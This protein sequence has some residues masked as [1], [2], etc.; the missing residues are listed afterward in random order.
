MQNRRKVEDRLTHGKKGV[1]K[2]DNYRLTQ[3][4]NSAGGTICSRWLSFV[5]IED[6]GLVLRQDVFILNSSRGDATQQRVKERKHLKAFTNSQD[7][8]VRAFE[9]YVLTNMMDS[10]I[11]SKYVYKNTY[12]IHLRN[13]N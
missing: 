5:Y 13:L 11:I 4:T 12:D 8:S 2:G 7:L 1:K 6:C 9:Y 3:A 10:N